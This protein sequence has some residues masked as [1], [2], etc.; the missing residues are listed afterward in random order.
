MAIINNKINN[1]VK[2]NHLFKIQ[3][4]KK[5]MLIYRKYNHLKINAKSKRIGII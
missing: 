4:F 2:K 5:R 1:L 3:T